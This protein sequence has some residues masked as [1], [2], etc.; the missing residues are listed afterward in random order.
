VLV[1]AEGRPRRV[2]RRAARQHSGEIMIGVLDHL[3]PVC[4]DHTEGG[5]LVP[6]LAWFS[7]HQPV[8]AK[9]EQHGPVVPSTAYLNGRPSTSLPGCPDESAIRSSSTWPMDEDAAVRRYLLVQ[10]EH[11][12][13]R[14]VRIGTETKGPISGA[15]RAMGTVA[16]DALSARARLV[17]KAANRRGVDHTWIP[18]AEASVHNPDDERG[19]AAP[20]ALQAVR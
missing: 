18:P 11:A 12:L 4:P 20:P 10:Y 3:Q 17:A 7:R 2:V 1:Y 9:A 14:I 15:A 19:M 5:S 8:W 16:A 13:H 6:R